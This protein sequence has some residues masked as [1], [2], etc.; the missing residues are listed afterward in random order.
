MI[1]SD[2][3]DD[4][5]QNGDSAGAGLRDSNGRTSATASGSEQKN[6]RGQNENE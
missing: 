1:L 2:D 4:V 5:R 3:D 6:Q